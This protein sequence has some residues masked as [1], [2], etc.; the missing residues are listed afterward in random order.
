MGY[1]NVKFPKGTRFLV[2]GAAGFI[3]SNLVEVLLKL[4]VYVR[5]FDNLSSGKMENITSFLDHPNFEF[6]EGDIR[7]VE[8]C[9]KSTVGIDYVLHQAA[10]GSVPRSIKYPAMYEENNIKGTLNIMEAA[11]LTGTVKRL[12]FA[13]SSSVYGDS[14]VLPKKEGEEGNLLSPY[15]I[16]KKVNEMYGALYTRLYGLPCIG[17]RYF[18]VFGRRQDPYS[19]YAAVIPSFAHQL[20]TG[21]SPTINGDGEQSRDFTY[22]E[23]VIEA[24]LKSCIAPLDA[25]G[26]SYNIAFGERFTVNQMYAKMCELLDTRTIPTYG[27]NRPGDIKHSL[28]DISHAKNAIGYNPSWSFERGF[29]QSVQWYKT[30]LGN[31]VTKGN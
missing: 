6:V 15:A 12:V 11:R 17:L 27:P 30:Y 31:L 13:S 20:L 25:C 16:T 21:E 24:N 2:T 14:P 8:A 7:D 3:G 18:N 23:N 29:E 28:A 22:I 5:G 10:L 9:M 4:G 26:Q 19:Q 1:E